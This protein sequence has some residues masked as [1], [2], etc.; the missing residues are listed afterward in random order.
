MI[1]QF[2]QSD[3]I[4]VEETA[5]RKNAAGMGISLVIPALNEDATIGDIVASARSEL[6]DRVPLLDEILVMDG[7]SSDTTRDQATRAGATV[8]DLRKIGPRDVPPGKGTAL[9][10][11][12]LV[13]KGDIVVCID[14]DITNF[15][16]H[17]VSGLVA[18][19]FADPQVSFVK[20]YY[21]RPIVADGATL[22]GAGGRVTEILVRPFLSTFYPELARLL[23]PLAGEYGFRRRIIEDIPFYSGYGVEIGLIL[24]MYRRFGV[25]RFA[26]VDMGVRY[27]RNRSLAALSKMSFGI[28]RVLLDQLQ[29]DGRLKLSCTLHETMVSRLAT[30]LVEENIAERELPPV[31]SLS[32]G[33][34]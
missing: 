17:F 27:H 8:L 7:G 14:A 13:A 24:E 19:M 12:L 15:G 3:I 5:A 23:Q 30:D 4:G 31:S 34:R 25:E 26:Q 1:R 32:E 16:P 18:P 11:S 20:A 28:L 33:E 9:W 22:D 10:K 21:D 2:G 6:M 29:R